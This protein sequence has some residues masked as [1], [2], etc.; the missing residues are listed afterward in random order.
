MSRFLIG[1]RKRGFTLIELLVVIAIIAILIGLLLPAVQKV[2]EAAARIQCSNNLKQIGLGLANCCDAHQ[3]LM[4]PTC[5]AY[6]FPCNP[7]GGTAGNG[8]GGFFFH[9]LPFIEQGN[10]YSTALTKQDGFNLSGVLTYSEY[11]SPTYGYDNSANPGLYVQSK[12]IKIFNCPSDPTNTGQPIN[13][14]GY[15]AWTWATAS[16]G[17]N[18]QVFQ[19]NRW[20]TGYGRYPAFITD[21]TSNTIFFTEKMAVGNGNCPGSTCQGYNYWADW[22]P[23]IA[24]TGAP[25]N[26]NSSSGGYWNPGPQGAAAYPL[27][28]PKPPGSQSSCVASTEHTA[29][30]LAALGD[31]SVRTVGQGVSAN[32]WW[33]AMTPN[34]GEV[35]GSDW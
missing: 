17:V 20:Q 12:V 22:G 29:V 35:L 32:S 27:I 26:Q 19:G 24:S 28:G 1:P 3:G 25:N 6:P 5:G 4:P 15:S 7:G 14:S 33:Y 31:G 11:G 13:D 34:G 10:L 16:Y 18:G 8:E 21:G 30:I 2:R 23:I 9:L